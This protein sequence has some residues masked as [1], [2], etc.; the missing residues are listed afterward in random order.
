MHQNS[1]NLYFVLWIYCSFH[2]PSCETRYE[3]N[4]QFKFTEIHD[5]HTQ[6]HT[7]AIR[8]DAFPSTVRG[9]RLHIIILLLFY[10]PLCNVIKT[11]RTHDYLPPFLLFTL[12]PLPQTF[13][14]TQKP[15]LGLP[16]RLGPIFTLLSGFSLHLFDSIIQ[17][18]GN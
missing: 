15:R 7:F 14:P 1:L 6:L 10:C 3:H 12:F 4:T 13:V 8:S 2:N 17:H 16:W 5:H 11:A 9:Y 18:C